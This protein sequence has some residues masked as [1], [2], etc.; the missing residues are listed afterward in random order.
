[1][2]ATRK[3]ANAPRKKKDLT[4][5]RARRELWKTQAVDLYLK[6]YSQRQVKDL[7]VEVTGGHSFGMNTI[8]KYINDAVKEWQASKTALVE[9][10]KAIE[11]EKINRL[12]A[13]YWEAWEASRQKV[14]SK[15]ERR[16]K[17]KETGGMSLAETRKDERESQGDPRYLQGLQWCVEQR[18]KILGVE[19][20]MVQVN[21]NLGQN[22]G[23][24]TNVYR[25]VV[26]KGKAI[27]AVQQVHT[28]DEADNN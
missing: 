25:R 10:Y 11:L 26:F 4:P 19:V 3:A 24:T 18:C 16:T 23:N 7:M 12:E 14:T 5:A 2:K 21:N 1:M 13:T 22:S 20:P 6:G 9:N 27:E 8:N 15:S 17:G 28:E